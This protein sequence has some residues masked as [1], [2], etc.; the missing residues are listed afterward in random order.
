MSE[1]NLLYEK[2]NH[3]AVLT[4]NR[5]DVR[6]A[7]NEELMK[8]IVDTLDQAD[9]DK[10]VRVIV[11][12]GSG[13]K[14]FSA[15]GD[16]NKLR[17]KTQDGVIGIREYT[18]NYA[19]LILAVNK[20]SKPIIASVQGYALAGGCG[21]AVACDLTVASDK[22]KFGV[23][24]INIGFWGAIITAPIVRAIGMKK[25]MDFFYTGR[26]VDATE[27]ERMGLINRV[28]PHAELDNEV[29]RLA[30]EISA[31][32]PLVMRIGREMFLTSQGMDYEQKVHYLRE[33]ATM[34][35]G[36]KD[37]YEGMT[38]F[39]EKREAKWQES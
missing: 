35:I 19:N 36:T 22:A 12:K 33:M 30:E 13:D 2:N 1:S 5:P 8:S 24:E 20:V 38:A 9:N 16:L 23:P 26:L 6:N 17:E 34:L 7:L 27:A 15:G 11:L 32:S 31:K 10:D 39:L 21:L 3:C 4:L 25:A 37:A 18:T 28:V 14:A 29:T